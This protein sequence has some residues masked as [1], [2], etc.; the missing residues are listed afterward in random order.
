MDILVIGAGPAGLYAAERFSEEGH[1]VVVLEAS[2]RVGGRAY[3]E[4]FEGA[5]VETGAGVG[6]WPHDRRLA[7]WMIKHDEKVDPIP[8]SLRYWK[9]TEGL[10]P[11]PMNVYDEVR[12]LPRP[13]DSQRRSTTFGGWLKSVAGSAYTRSF[14]Y[15]S[16]Y[17]DY[18]KAD[19]VDTI[20]HY[21]FQD[22][23][24]ESGMF[25]P[26]WTRLF[27]KVV[28]YLKARGV[29]FHLNE[30]A[31]RVTKDHGGIY[32]V[33]SEKHQYTTSRVVLAIPARPA[34]R[35]LRR[36]GYIDSA[37]LLQGIKGQPF[38]RAYVQFSGPTNYIEK[39]VGDEI[40]CESPFRKIIQVNKTKRVY[41]IAYCDNAPTRLWARLRH[42]PKRKAIAEVRSALTDM[43]G[44]S[45]AIDD[46]RIYYH[47]EATHYFTPLPLPYTTRQKFLQDVV[48][49]DRKFTMVGEAVALD[50]GWTNSAISTVSRYIQT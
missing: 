24:P 3:N 33:T 9:R 44:E 7:E 46:L 18:L 40:V 29:V 16:S 30:A 22:I 19:I 20:D 2:H 48:H 36:S 8:C 28:K 11:A 4:P 50:Q 21:H 13:T 39:N 35:L 15:T 38:V 31:I 49:I 32:S 17:N 26:H 6:R 23:A 41:M 25:V 45:F 43:F 27:D 37:N 12:A 5:E 42:L 1:N 47:K 10:I 14:I 34:E